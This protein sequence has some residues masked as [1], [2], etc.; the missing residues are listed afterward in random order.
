[1][2][3]TSLWAWPHQNSSTKNQSLAGQQLQN[4]QQ[5][6]SY[7]FL[8]KVPHS[9]KKS[10]T[11]QRFRHAFHDLEDMIYLLCARRLVGSVT[12]LLTFIPY[13]SPVALKL[14]PCESQCLRPKRNFP[15][16]WCYHNL[17][18]YQNFSTLVYSHCLCWVYEIPIL[19]NVNLSNLTPTNLGWSDSNSHSILRH[20][21]IYH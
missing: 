21:D 19:K 12:W 6:F 8:M 20:K 13:T 7:C 11:S 3:R 4:L 15:F 17:R 18:S 14:I 16:C 9:L 2:N 10:V 5:Q 1:M